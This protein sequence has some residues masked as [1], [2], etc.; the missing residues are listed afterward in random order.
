MPI[1]TIAS[2]ASEKTVLG[3]DPGL[4]HCGWAILRFSP[5]KISLIDCGRFSPPPNA[6]LEKRLAALF[7]QT[8]NIIE[9]FSPDCA[10]I[11]KTFVNSSPDASLK[12]GFA[13]GAI[14]DALGQSGAEVIEINNR[15]IK[16]SVS[17][18][19][20]ADKTQIANALRLLFPKECAAIQSSDSADAV[21]TAFCCGNLSQTQMKWAAS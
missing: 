17:G 10:G 6:A 9:K 12:L 3:I 16:K 13:R 20:N 11:E 15:L 8:L 18:Y 7:S 14:L 5:L 19:G 4:R 21:A 2:D 1:K